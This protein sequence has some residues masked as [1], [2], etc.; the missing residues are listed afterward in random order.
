MIVTIA[1]SNQVGYF[2]TRSLYE[3]ATR[4]KQMPIIKD[5]I[6]PPCEAVIASNIMKTDVVTLQNVDS[7]QNILKVCLTSHHAFPVLNSRGNVV[8]L[9]PK[10]YVLTLI[11]SRA[12]YRQ[13]GVVEVQDDI[14]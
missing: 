7:V 4:G 14:S 5:T 3:R 10:N 9:M 13:D 1:I 11:K 6:P 2:F 12:F 8:G